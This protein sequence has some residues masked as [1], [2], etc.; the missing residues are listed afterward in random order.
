M[1]KNAGRQAS[2][3]VCI[4]ALETT[5]IQLGLGLGELSEFHMP[6]T[7]KLGTEPLPA[8]ASFWQGFGYF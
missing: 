8:M 6:I 5:E 4:E 1:N 3:F 7:D 2:I